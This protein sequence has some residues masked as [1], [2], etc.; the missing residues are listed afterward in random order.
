MKTRP[1][2]VPARQELSVQLSS[3]KHQFWL[4]AKLP[5][6]AVTPRHVQ[7]DDQYGPWHDHVQLNGNYFPPCDDRSWASRRSPSRTKPARGARWN[8]HSS[9]GSIDPPDAVIM[10]VV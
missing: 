5:R 2:I 10:S 8:H 6:P 9:L 4:P 3:R 1:P 7:A